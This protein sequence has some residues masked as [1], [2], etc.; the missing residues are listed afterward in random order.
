MITELRYALEARLA[1]DGL[2][3]GM[4][5]RDPN[6]PFAPRPAILNSR[7]GK[8]PP[9]ITCVVYRICTED[10][11]KRFRP[12]LPST[13][14]AGPDAT[15]PATDVRV[16]FQSYTQ[17][18]SGAVHESIKDRL[19]A[20]LDNQAWLVPALSPSGAYD[21][22]GVPIA[23]VHKGALLTSQPNLYDDKLNA[24]LG[25]YS[26]LLRVIRRS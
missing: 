2:L 10:P 26:F 21:P 11:D 18:A 24:H 3:D 20:L 14:P 1:A 15:S 22:A 6:V 25:L 5:D 19:T 8:A 4:L 23:R 16:D 17:K 7:M 12:A 9:P 13:D